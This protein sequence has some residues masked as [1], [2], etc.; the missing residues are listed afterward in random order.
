MRPSRFRD[1]FTGVGMLFRGFATW[2]TAPGRMLLG[3]I[4]AV[5][6]AAAFT[7]GLVVLALNIEALATAATP[8][9]NDWDRVWRDVTRVAVAIAFLIAAILLIS[10]T[11]TTITLI[12]GQP[13][14]ELVWRHAESRLGGIPDRAPGFWKSVGLGITSGLRMLIPTVLIGVA[15]FALGL[16]PV[17]GAV[18]SAV[19][20]ALVGGW[21]LAL[22]LTGLAFD[23]RGLGF[24]ERRA[25][26]RSR[27]ALV[28]GYGAAT[29]LLFLVP[30]GAVLVM[31]AAV[32]ASVVVTRNVLG[33]PTATVGRTR[34]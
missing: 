8:F 27:R 18:L 15:L 13:F 34:S 9:A 28:L 4:P 10:L 33:E 19:L 30:L 31:P 32:A 23:A 11:F 6:V 24:R 22:E 25:A 1:F 7:A 20:G 2:R 26:L 12:V 14:Y 17:V 16:V 29:Y 21:F 3:L 5:I